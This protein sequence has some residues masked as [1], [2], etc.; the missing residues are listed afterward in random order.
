VLF[1]RRR[2]EIERR[3]RMRLHARTGAGP[4]LLFVKG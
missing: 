4:S 3:D 1:A 2:E